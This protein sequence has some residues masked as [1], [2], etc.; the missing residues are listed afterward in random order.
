MLIFPFF[1]SPQAYLILFFAYDHIQQISEKCQLSVIDSKLFYR[2]TRNSA[3]KTAFEAFNEYT[4]QRCHA[5]IKSV[6]HRQPLSLQCQ[7]PIGR[8]LSLDTCRYFVL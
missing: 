4:S 7:E 1:K 6:W 5:N 2:D 3:D 8:G